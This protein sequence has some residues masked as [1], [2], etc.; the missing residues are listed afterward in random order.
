MVEESATPQSSS[1]RRCLMSQHRVIHRLVVYGSSSQAVEH[2]QK[3]EVRGRN[4][5]VERLSE[6]RNIHDRPADA[7]APRVAV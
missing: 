3:A 4:G 1:D 7:D 5:D 2:L 6:G